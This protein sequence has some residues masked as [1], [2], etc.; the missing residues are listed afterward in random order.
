VVGGGAGRSNPSGI[1]ARVS[2]IADGRTQHQEVL[3]SWGHSNT[4]SDGWLTFGLGDACTLDAIEV[5]WPDA[6]GTVTRYDDVMPNHPIEIVEGEADV[7][8]VVR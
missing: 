3:G 4:Q 1:G 6:A 5:R 7:T 8:Y 2:V